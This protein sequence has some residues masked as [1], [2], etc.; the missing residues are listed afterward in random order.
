MI[1]LALDASTI[2]NAYS[3]DGPISIRNVV[4]D[5]TEANI[6][7][8]TFDVDTSD[9]SHLDDVGVQCSG[10]LKHLA[11]FDIFVVLIAK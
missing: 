4:C 6:L 10:N 3:G 9:C 7:E 1:A 8:C 5:G 2:S 11:V